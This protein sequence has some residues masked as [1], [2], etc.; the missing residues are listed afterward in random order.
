MTVA[1]S[2][3]T[4]AVSHFPVAFGPFARAGVALTLAFARP[5]EV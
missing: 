1:M 3:T 4:E 2:S 5:V